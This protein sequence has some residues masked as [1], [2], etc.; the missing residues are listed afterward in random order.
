M[1]NSTS[2]TIKPG[3][4]SLNHLF[5]IYRARPTLLLAHNAYARMEQS[6][7]IVERIAAAGEAVYGVNTGFGKLADQ[8][9]SAADLDTLQRNLILSHA[10]AWANRCPMLS[11]G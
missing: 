8:R 3:T 6:R 9:I 10:A 5:E 11:C 2:I 1:T 4:L 7:A